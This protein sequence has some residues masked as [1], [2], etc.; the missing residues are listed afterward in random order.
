VDSETNLKLMLIRPQ[1]YLYTCTFNI[2]EFN[3]LQE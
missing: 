2:Y 1:E 3:M